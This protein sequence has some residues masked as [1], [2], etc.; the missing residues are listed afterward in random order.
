MKKYDHIYRKEGCI[1]IMIIGLLL[2]PISIGIVLKLNTFDISQLTRRTLNI[3]LCLMSFLYIMA[4]ILFNIEPFQFEITRAFDYLLAFAVVFIFSPFLWINL[5]YCCQKLFKKM[6]VHKNTKIKSN[7]QYL[8]YRDDL[9]KVPPS[10]VMFA[11][12]M[13]IDVKKCVSAVLLKLKLNGYIQEINHEFKCTNKNRNQLLESEKMVLQSVQ[14]KNLH[15]KSYKKLVEKEALD[16]GYVKK[17][18]QGKVMK[19]IKIAVTLCIPVLCIIASM[20]F[21]DYVFNHYKT[22]TYAGER[23]V[24]IDNGEIGDIYYG[25]IKN[26]DDYYHGYVKEGN[27]KKIFYDKALMR[28]DKFDNPIVRKTTILQNLD[29]LFLVVSLIMT[30]VMVFMAIE[31][32][33]YFNR[34]YIRTIKG[35]EL[36]NKAY[37]LKNYLKEFSLIHE[38]TE[39]ELILWEY[40]LIYAVILDVN[41]KVEEH[42]IKNYLTI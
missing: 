41:G 3:L 25:Q 14:D 11:S 7:Q 15:E 12:I 30:F 2:C 42:M 34:D 32:I 20:K 16:H 37:A 10:I 40:Y 9:N 33:I 17:N 38:K 35:N 4:A 21:D 29:A 27:K 8:Y 1:M 28:A 24:S 18:K 23:Y 6:R 39:E 13:E 31:Q 36:L 19:L 22:Y 5:Y 26:I